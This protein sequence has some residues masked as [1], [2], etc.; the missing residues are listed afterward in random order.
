MRKQVDLSISS[1]SNEF[2]LFYLTVL[3]HEREGQSHD[4]HNSKHGKKVMIIERE[5]E[6][7]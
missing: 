5:K 4:E 3:F 6:R 7:E 2:L 1:H